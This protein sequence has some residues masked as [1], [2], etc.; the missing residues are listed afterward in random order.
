MCE[1][2]A[3]WRIRDA[4]EMVAGGTL[5]LAAGVARVAFQRLIAVGTIK[6]KFFYAHRL[7]LHHAQIGRNNTQKIYSCF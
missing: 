7:H 1:T 3:W 6:F 2:G 4:D 5:N